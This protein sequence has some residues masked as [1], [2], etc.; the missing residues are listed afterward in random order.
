MLPLNISKAYKNSMI[1]KN[2]KIG[3]MFTIIELIYDTVNLIDKFANDIVTLI[4]TN[5]L[6][7]LNFFN[8]NLVQHTL[9]SKFEFCDLYSK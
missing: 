3:R 6:I 5:Y 4:F 7:K 8:F 9:Y 1:S 2:Q